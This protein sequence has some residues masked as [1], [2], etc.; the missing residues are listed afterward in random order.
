MR[1]LL[2]MF[3]LLNAPVVAQESAPAPQNEDTVAVQVGRVITLSGD[4]I[5][6]GTILIEKGQIK[7][8]GKGLEVPWN[9]KVVRFPLATAMPG[10]IQVH[11]TMGLRVPNENVPNAAYISVL[12]G[13]DPSSQA[14]KGSLRDGVTVAHVIPAN[15]T[16]IGGQGAVVR[17]TGRT[18]E[19]MVIKSPSAMKISLRPSIGETRMQT[20]AALRKT[21]FDLY[22]QAREVSAEGATTLLSGKPPGGISLASIVESRAEWQEIAWDKMNLEKLSTELRPLADVVRGKLSCFISCPTASDIFKA[23]ELIDSNHLKA[24]LILGPDAYKLVPV[25]KARIDLGPVVLD[26]DLVY[27]ETDPETLEERRFLTAR[28]LFD[29]GIRF[30][31]QTVPDLRDQG[32][33]LS[34]EGELHLWYQAAQLVRIGIPRAEALKAVTSTP[35]KILGLDYR[36]GTIEPGKDANIAIF[37]GDPLD[38]RSWVEAVLIEGK[39]VYRRDK[40]RELEALL[41]EPEKKF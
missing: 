4:E 16:R 22:L 40:D 2:G 39:E 30:A 26:S 27:W 18:V 37:S 5:D 7:A 3:L 29:A 20:I 32:P 33:R 1:K 9:A 23:F 24:T 13:L 35:A 34:R 15:A 11:T 14:I 17:T 28:I 8:V 41:K 21:F 36:M 10:L 19:A 38:A 12:D 25:L 31:V 6:G